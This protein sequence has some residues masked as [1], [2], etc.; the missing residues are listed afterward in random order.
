MTQWNVVRA[1]RILVAAGELDQDY[2]DRVAGD[3]T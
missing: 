2:L 1:G 3:L